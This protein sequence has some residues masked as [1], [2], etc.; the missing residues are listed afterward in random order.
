[1]RLTN[2]IRREFVKNVMADVPRSDYA[3]QIEQVL[4]DDAVAQLPPPVRALWDDPKLRKYVIEDNFW[5]NDVSI[6]S[7]DVPCSC[8][9]RLP[10]TEKAVDQVIALK[11]LEDAQTEAHNDLRLRLN[12]I[13]KSCGTSESLAKKLPE[14]EKY[15]PSAA[16]PSTLPVLANLAADFMKAGWPKDKAP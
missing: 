14:F 3:S 12:A 5:L 8:E 9:G 15:I 6:F 11:R 10:F 13:V 4:L 1:M 2:D 16:A 7:P